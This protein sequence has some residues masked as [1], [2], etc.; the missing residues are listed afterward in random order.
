MGGQG[1]QPRCAETAVR[2]LVSCIQREID[3]ANAHLAALREA[4]SAALS[5][6]FIVQEE[7]ERIARLKVELDEAWKQAQR[8]IERLEALSGCTEPRARAALSASQANARGAFDDLWIL[9]TA[10]QRGK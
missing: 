8:S 4:V 9:V 10:P 1:E 5:K 2:E 7:Q 6:A 3:A